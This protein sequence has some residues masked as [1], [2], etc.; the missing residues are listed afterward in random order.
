MIDLSV[1]VDDTTALPHT[2]GL[3]AALQAELDRR[4][5][6]TD[7]T[8]AVLAP[9]AEYALDLAP[10]DGSTI[11]VRL[12]GLYPS[13]NNFPLQDVAPSLNG[14]LL[15]QVY[16]LGV[17]RGFIPPDNADPPDAQQLSDGARLQLADAAAIYTAI[18]SYFKALSIP[19]LMGTYS[20]Y[21]PMGAVV[22]GSW[23]VTAGTA[24]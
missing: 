4:G 11:W 13:T 19:Y 2:Q 24:F 10:E 17:V 22:G 18:C 9:G 15:A 5:T 6:G 1:I 3:L 20:P 14:T 12:Q 7:V 8:A 21:G 16:E 23:Q